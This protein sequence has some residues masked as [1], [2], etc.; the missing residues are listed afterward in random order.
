ML[1]GGDPARAARC[2]EGLTQRLGALKLLNGKPAAPQA[3]R[4]AAAAAA[5]APQATKRAAAAAIDLAPSAKESRTA[6]PQHQAIGSLQAFASAAA[7]LNSCGAEQ[8]KAELQRLGLKCG[9]TPTMRAER[10]WLT[11][12]T[13]L[14]QLVRIA[15]G[16]PQP[17]P[18]AAPASRLTHKSS[19][20]VLN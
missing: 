6:A 13:P 1:S 15:A 10:L 5:A 8:I 19:H 14:D 11:K 4:D 9:G 2:L 12:H 16:P 18:S 7:M 17:V 20:S 3:V